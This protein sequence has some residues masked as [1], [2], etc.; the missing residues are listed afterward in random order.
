MKIKLT[1]VINNYFIYCLNNI[2]L[3]STSFILIPFLVKYMSPKDYGLWTLFNSLIGFIT[4]FTGLGL[5]QFLG[6]EYFHNSIDNNRSITAT[7][8]CY[9]SFLMTPILFVLLLILPI[10]NRYILIN[11][12]PY[13]LIL[14]GLLHIFLYFFNEL[15]FQLLRYHSQVNKLTLIQ[16]F[17]LL[18]NI[19]SVVI[20]VVILHWSV[21]GLAVSGLLSMLVTFI[22]GIF[23][24]CKCG[25]NTFFEIPNISLIGYHVKKGL[26]FIPNMLSAWFLASGPRWILAY[27]GNLEDVGLYALAD[28]CTQ[29]YDLVIIQPLNSA[30]GPYILEKLAHNKNYLQLTEQYNKNIMYICMLAISI[31]ASL[32]YYLLKPYALLLLPVKYHPVIHYAWLIVLGNIFLTGGY[33]ASIYIQ[34]FKQIRYL[35]FAWCLPALINILLNMH[36]IPLWQVYGCIM[37]NTLTYALYFILLLSYNYWL[38][39]NHKPSQTL[40]AIN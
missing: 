31:I 10:I 36:L 40:I 5:R 37:S 17:S 18:I 14:I 11:K 9:Y 30:Y 2:I 38:I 12:V 35:T 20:T 27:Y 28:I 13:P 7:I 6:M 1:K 24:Y 3:R 4:I 33:F 34:F 15:F 22:I 26:P 16:S 23:A 8:I 39:H 19:F 25:Y 29:V 32:G 21:L